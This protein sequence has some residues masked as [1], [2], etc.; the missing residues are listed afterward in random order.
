[1]ALPSFFK[2]PRHKSFNYTPRYYD[3]RKE[4]ME[5]RIKNAEQELG[6][7]KG[8]YSPTIKKGSFREYVQRGKAVKHQS[9]FRLIVILAALL[10]LAYLILTR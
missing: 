5:E 4:R 8:G 3:E 6:L 1:M 9:N 10:L 2:T 7:N